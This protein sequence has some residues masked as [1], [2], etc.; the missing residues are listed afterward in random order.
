MKKRGIQPLHRPSLRV[1]E[2]EELQGE[3]AISLYLERYA[4]RGPLPV[5]GIFE[6][7]TE[8]RGNTV[9]AFY[10]AAKGNLHL[11]LGFLAVSPQ[12]SFAAEE[13]KSDIFNITAS[14]ESGT[15]PRSFR[16]APSGFLAIRYSIYEVMDPEPIAEDRVDF[17]VHGLVQNRPRLPVRSSGFTSTYCSADRAL[18]EMNPHGQRHGTKL[19]MNNAAEYAGLYLWE[20]QQRQAVTSAR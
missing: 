17:F 12:E 15:H 19:L 3:G 9:I 11:P 1:G 5:F 14:E 4:E 20:E 8:T 7:T 18:Y 6:D 16:Y 2:V 10:Q 13:Q